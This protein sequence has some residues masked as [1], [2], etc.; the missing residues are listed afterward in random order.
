MLCCLLCEIHEARDK[1]SIKFQGR[2]RPDE[3]NEGGKK[4]LE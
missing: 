4:V 1:G 2:R 3:E